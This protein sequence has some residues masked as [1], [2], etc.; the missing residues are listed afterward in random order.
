M[1][2]YYETPSGRKGPVTIYQLRKMFLDGEV[3]TETMV[4]QTG[5]E[6]SIPIVELID[7]FFREE[8]NEIKSSLDVT[9][10]QTINEQEPKGDVTEGILYLLA[11]IAVVS[12]FMLAMISKDTPALVWIILGIVEAVFFASIAK[13]LNYLNKIEINTRKD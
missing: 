5:M 12:G 6:H 2:W 13:I 3:N 7:F 4:C 9:K 11:F 1:Q 10:E 8:P